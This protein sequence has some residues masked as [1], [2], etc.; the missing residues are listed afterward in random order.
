[1]AMND[2]FA[3]IHEEPP[4]VLDGAYVD[5]LQGLA[6]AVIPRIPEVANRLLHEV[7]RAEVLP[8]SEM[9]ANIVNIG[10]T[11]T[12]RDDVAGRTQTA[13]LV[14]PPDADIA[15]QRI[16]ILTPIGA[17]LIGL[18]EGASITWE[19]RGGKSRRLTVTKVGAAPS[20][21]A[22]EPSEK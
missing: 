17:A 9:P 6:L 10:T 13:T 8:S 18:S 20:H 11:V 4:V 14:L 19:T 7:E 2:D 15:R 12:F 1:M 16:S 21:Q 22:S 5:R 3:N